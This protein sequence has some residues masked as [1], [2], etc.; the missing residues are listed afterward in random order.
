MESQQ[1]PPLALFFTLCFLFLVGVVIRFDHHLSRQENVQDSLLFAERLVL[2]AEFQDVSPE[3]AEQLRGVARAI[4]SDEATLAVIDGGVPG[5]DAVQE[6]SPMF[7]NLVEYRN[8][9]KPELEAQLRAESERA[10]RR[11]RM[12]AGFLVGIWTLAL[13]SFFFG[14]K[15]ARTPAAPSVWSSLGIVGLFLG[16]DA[17]NFFGVNML[18]SAIHD[19]V[20]RFW[21]ILLAQTLAYGFLGVL[22]V[23]GT[24]ARFKEFFRSFPWSWVG[25]GYLLAMLSVLGTNIL[26]GALLGESPRSMNPLLGVFA[27]AAPWQV[28]VLALLVVVVGPFFEELL[29]RGWLLGGLRRRLGDRRALIVSALLFSLI[30]G[31]PYATPALFVLGLVFGWVYLRSG[32]VWASTLVHAMWN[33]TTFS[34]LLSGIP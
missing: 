3:Q 19:A 11:F 7:G 30:H 4:K 17:F 33:A 24:G 6:L 15:E 29:F 8:S 20:P 1:K 5:K 22:I 26:V 27:E 21:L 34:F 25:R 32:S 9:Q 28:T 12:S 14:G 18:V 13:V 2:V 23:L 16:W 10:V 31:D